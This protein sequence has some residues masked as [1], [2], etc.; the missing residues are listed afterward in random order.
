MKI[1]KII[2]F[3]AFIFSSYLLV[4]SFE[5]FLKLRQTFIE[6][7]IP[8]PIPWPL[9]LELIFAIVSIIF[10]FYLWKKEKKGEKVKFALLISIVLLIAPFLALLTSF[11]YFTPI[12]DLMDKINP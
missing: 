1:A 6:L 12:Y 10:F 5:I 8:T 7:Q 3:I 9:I 2:S 4:R 11:V